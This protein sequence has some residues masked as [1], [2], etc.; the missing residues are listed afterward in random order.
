M[1]PPSYFAPWA[2]VYFI[3]QLN[4]H[5]GGMSQEIIAKFPEDFDPRNE[6]SRT[7]LV[8]Q[9]L[10]AVKSALEE[11]DKQLSD[12]NV[13]AVL[14]DSSSNSFESISINN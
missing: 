3:Y 14:F 5:I 6:S 1:R 2:D 11:Q 9:A 12:F 8:E 10:S 4:F 13:R 7:K